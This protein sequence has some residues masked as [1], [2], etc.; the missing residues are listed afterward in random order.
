MIVT[1]TPGLVFAGIGSMVPLA[2]AL[3]YGMRYVI[4]AETSELRANSGSTIKDKVDR[5]VGLAE[6]AKISAGVAADMAERS[7]DRAKESAAV[8]RETKAAL[9]DHMEHASKA[10]RKGAET[11]AEI[12]DMLRHGQEADDEIRETISNLAVAVRVAAQSTPPA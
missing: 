11:E 10:A 7:A 1:V 12:R 2:G 8:A 4:R 9:D 5:V 3:F 6:E